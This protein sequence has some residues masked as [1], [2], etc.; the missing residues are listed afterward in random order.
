[1]SD[2]PTRLLRE[3]LR[4]HMATEPS[5]GCVDSNTLAAWSDGTL[6]ARER[7]AVESHFS[8]CAAVSVVARRDDFNGAAGASAHMVADVE[9]WLA[10]APHRGRGRRTR[11]VDECP[12]D[13][14]AR[15]ARRAADACGSRLAGR[16]CRHPPRRRHSRL[17]CGGRPTSRRS[18]CQSKDAVTLQAQGGGG[19]E[20]PWPPRRSPARLSLRMYDDTPP[21]SRH[22]DWR[23]A[24]THNTSSAAAWA[25]APK[26]WQRWPWRQLNACRRSE[27]PLATP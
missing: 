23:L 16:Y 27:H 5:P 1:M 15:A 19:R 11:V 10:G 12:R 4:D 8:N 22:G 13:A 17:R 7:A 24:P 20:S 3:A 26:R 14:A 6:S 9:A 18:P 21:K 2:V 25:H